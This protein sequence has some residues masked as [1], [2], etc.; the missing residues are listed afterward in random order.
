MCT[1][2]TIRDRIV[3]LVQ[4]IVA[5]AALSLPL[6]VLAQAPL[7]T[8]IAWPDSQATALI[9]WNFPLT[10]GGAVSTIQIRH[11]S[12]GATVCSAYPTPVSLF[13][14]DVTLTNCDWADVYCPNYI[15]D[16]QLQASTTYVDMVTLFPSASNTTGQVTS[17]V[18]LPYTTLAFP[19]PSITSFQ[20]MS[21]T[22]VLLTTN[23]SSQY[24]WGMNVYGCPGAGCTNF[25]S[26]GTFYDGNFN[27]NLAL[28]SPTTLS[29]GVSGLTPATDYTFYVTAF[30]GVNTSAASPTFTFET[31]APDTTPPTPPT[32][33]AAQVVSGTEID[34]SYGS[35]TDNLYLSVYEIQRCAGS[36]CTNFTVVGSPVPGLALTYAD[37]GLTPSTTYQYS[38][39]AIDGSGNQSSPS[40]VVTATTLPG[41]PATLTAS[42]TTTTQV[43]LTWTPTGNVAGLAAY[44][45][46]QCSGVG[47]T[48]FSQVAQVNAP[49]EQIAGLTPATT[50]QFRVRSVD[51][52]GNDSG[53][54]NVVSVTT[55]PI[56]APTGPNATVLSDSQITLTWTASTA[57]N[58]TAYL[59]ERCS[60]AGCKN[61]DQIGSVASFPYM[62][63]GLLPL[64]F[65]QYRIRAQDA[66]GNLSDY[67]TVSATTLTLGAPTGLIGVAVST[68]QINLS[69]F[70]S[71]S[72]GAAT[73][74]VARCS[75]VGCTSFAQI[76]T[77]SGATY[78]DTGLT[79][80][81]TYVY[82]VQGT[83]SEGAS[84]GYSS[85]VAV[86]TFALAP[87][88]SL[89]ATAASSSQVNLSWT[90]SASSGATNYIV[91]RCNGAGCNGFTTIAN[92]ASLSYADSGLGAATAYSYRVQATDS[93]GDLSA[94]SNIASTQTMAGSGGGS[95]GGGG[96]GGGTGS[97][98][99]P[100]TY[101]YDATGHLRQ[102]VT[103]SG[104]TT[105]TY[106]AAGHVVSI[107]SG[108]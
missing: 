64:T 13:Q 15:Y 61:F 102:V 42:N 104:T 36:G 56:A 80:N 87:A 16:T 88:T 17:V 70:A 63:G 1:V 39:I 50:Y 77:V 49:T 66:A 19:V 95:T 29:G 14:G 106:D 33:L 89:T 55:L 93:G 75:G 6:P 2:S 20:P 72:T 5:L 41:A 38:V 105:Y 71:P 27:P 3:E 85:S 60:G 9:I 57:L 37:T 52:S 91:Q 46:E 26:L 98:S 25:E 54:S 81:T 108:P 28:P 103:S 83:N 8:A 22:S 45:I 94:A 11:C 90:A 67:V 21:G 40:N 97:G 74:L 73:Y 7:G 4:V 62:D 78:S 43:T 32:S 82:E 79:A 23:E 101:I 68:S 35:S 76:A 99:N 58:V 92:V 44:L 69:W 107:Q 65:Y 86:T 30:D 48:N 47:C 51:P 12:A 53:Y 96:P 100:A 31:P 34:L 10:G 24:Y 18:T 84:S 59:I